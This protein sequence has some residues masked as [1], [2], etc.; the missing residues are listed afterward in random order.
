M[1]WRL[2]SILAGTGSKREENAIS[3]RAEGS[4]PKED[5]TGWLNGDAIV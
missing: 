2:S 5:D 3:G 4:H 1:R